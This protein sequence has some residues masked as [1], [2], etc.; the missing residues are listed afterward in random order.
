MAVTL[1]WVGAVT[2][3]GAVIKARTTE[4][5]ASV[6]TNPATST[7]NG[8]EGND[9]VFTFILTGLSA[10]TEYVCTIDDGSTYQVTFTTAPSGAANFTFAIAGD[11]GHSGGDFDVDDVS[12]TAPTWQ[13]IADAD[14]AFLLQIGDLHYRDITTDTVA[15]FRTAYRDV[16]ADDCL[17]M[18]QTVPLGAYVWDDHDFGGNDSD[19]TSAAKPAA[20]T[21]FRDYVPSHPLEEAS[22]LWHSFVWGR[23]RFVVLDC[24]ND[25]SPRTDT[26]DADKTMLGAT[27]KTWLFDLLENST[28]PLLVVVMPLVWIGSP[29][30]SA[31]WWGGYTTER[32]EVAEKLTAEGWEYRVLFVSADAHMM[33]MDNGRN[34]QYDPTAAGSAV[35]GPVVFQAGGIDAGK[36]AIG[37]PYSEGTAADANRQ[38]FG[39]VEI[40]DDGTDIDV[41]LSGWVVASDS[42]TTEAQTLTF[43]VGEEPPMAFPQITTVGTTDTSV[44]PWEFNLPVGIVAGDELLLVVVNQDNL[45]WPAA[46]TGWTLVRESN[47]STDGW[48]IYRKTAVGGETTVTGGPAGS[49]DDAAAIAMRVAAGGETLG[50]AI[51]PTTDSGGSGT[52]P[53]APVLDPD[54]STAR[55]FTWLAIAVCSANHTGANTNSPTNY[56]EIG[57][58]SANTLA[59]GRVALRE[60]NAASETPGSYPCVGGDVHGW[61]GLTAAYWFVA[62]V[63]DAPTNPAATADSQT[64]ITVTWDDVADETGFRVE[65]SPDGSGS[66]TDVSG[67]LA[68]GT[69]SYPDTGLTCNTQYF[70]RVFA[71]NGDGDSAASSTVNATTDACSPPPAGGGNRMGGTGAI[72]RMGGVR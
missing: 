66:W 39:T 13:A 27:Q 51:S 16:L 22:G 55:D 12:P 52:Q 37:G 34:S 63:P 35:R 31:D 67:N 14:P 65:R 23:V 19:G 70:Y 29:T 43:T 46:P 41:T 64:Q 3:T 59:N 30:T 24:R 38:I 6:T 71:F 54:S 57:D 44:S 2:T 7:F 4:A 1:A 49:S 72:R 42:T 18:F 53:T 58:Q 28:E 50:F 68:A 36:I 61:R 17:T 10:A 48:H 47:M 26:D 20:N 69:T 32:Q 62:A 25:K 60:F 9:D 40:A 8:V 5:A 33:A 15:S 56:N 45:A 11:S 21:A